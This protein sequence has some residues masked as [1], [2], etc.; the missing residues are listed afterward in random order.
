MTNSK[1]ASS[2]HL[3]ERLKFLKLDAQAQ[4]RLRALAP[5]VQ[6]SVAP[7]LEEFYQIIAKMPDLHRHF[8]SEP[9][10]QKARTSQQQH[11]ARIVS[12]EFGDD[13]AL[14]VR[15]IGAVHAR[16]GLEPRW[17]IGGY[18]L[19]LD[20]IVR[21]LVTDRR[22]LTA[23]ARGQLAADLSTVMRAALL[24][25][26][27]SISTY[28]EQIE[29]RRREAEDT[30][31]RAFELLSGALG[32]LA[33]GDMTIRLEPVLSERTRFNET[34]N[35]LDEMLGSVRQSAQLISTGTRRIS[36]ASNDMA[37]RTEQQ[38][39][40]L[41]QT[42]AALNEMTASVRESAARSR[43][44]EEMAGRARQ[45]ATQ[46]SQVMDQ[47]RAAMAEVS[48]S[49]S[50]MG[51]IIGVISEIA[52]Q[53]SLLALNAGVEA[54]RA[55][56]A[57]RGFAVVAAEVR[58][59]AQRSADA[60][61]TIRELIDRSVEQTAHG[62]R[63]VTE[64]DT[65]L[66]RIVA[67]FQDIETIVTEMSATAQRQALSITEINSAV[68]YLDEVTQKNAAMVEEATST[69][70]LLNTEAQALT[71]LVSRFTVTSDAASAPRW[72]KAI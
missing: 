59:L 40:S 20:H 55:G 49:A 6:S 57:G 3:E 69:S 45:V 12:A 31:H 33:E 10:R 18:G 2:V 5:Q 25:I 50:E 28:L 39:A 16:I 19:V 24:D 66:A 42:A 15:R 22:T 32:R 52:F 65:T 26:D 47:T 48:A 17:Y 62:V 67:V 27:L 21:D 58:A 44:A 64:T 70:A 23:S 56:E 29:G 38:A 54:A 7:A 53:T 8:E 35:S 43:A 41:E 72:R 13:Y 68:S 46:G 71:T 63:L 51:Q 4:A 61:R 11:W 1:G 60:V 14:A 34:V 36:D 9:H 37:R 30:Q